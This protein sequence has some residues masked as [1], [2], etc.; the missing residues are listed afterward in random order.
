MSD[1]DGMWKCPGLAQ[2]CCSR[3]SSSNGFRTLGGICVIS[4]TG[5][6][7]GMVS[8]CSCPDDV[9]LL[10]RLSQKLITHIRRRDCLSRHTW[11]HSTETEGRCPRSH[12]NPAHPSFQRLS[13][14]SLT[15]LYARECA[16]M[17]KYVRYLHMKRVQVQY[18][19][20]N[21]SIVKL[22]SK[23]RSNQRYSLI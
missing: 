9:I 19:C 4:E 12:T 5:T 21:M 17:C 10:A 2:S 1:W 7:D 22:T 8:V 20:F 13:L 11:E 3:A 15:L 6:S 16:T 18:M 14:V 23:A